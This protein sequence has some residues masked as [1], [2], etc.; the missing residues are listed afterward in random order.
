MTKGISALPSCLL[1]RFALADMEE[2]QGRLDQ[3]KQTRSPSQ[4]YQGL[5]DQQERE[6]ASAAIAGI[7]QGLVDQ[8]EGEAAAAIIYQGLV[9]QLEGEQQKQLQQIYQGLVDQ[10]EGEAAAAIAAGAEGASVQEQQRIPH[11]LG[12]ELGSLV[13]IQFMRYL[14]R[15]GDAMGSRQAGEI[16]PSLRAISKDEEIIQ[17]RKPRH[18]AGLV[19]IQY[20]RYLRRSGNAMGSRQLFIRARKWGNSGLHVK[21]PWQIYAAAAL[22]EWQVLPKLCP[23]GLTNFRGLP[24]LCLLTDNCRGLPKVGPY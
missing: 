6:E 20:M 24:K 4:I 2:L 16:R 7:Y 10:L 13:W 15:S 3:A 22:I 8:L 5:V 14:R 9:D 12:T 23:I 21:A 17:L 11:S 1:L 19:W 18:R